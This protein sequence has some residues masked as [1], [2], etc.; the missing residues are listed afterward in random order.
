MAK[1]LEPSGYTS[2][3][4]SPSSMAGAAW[5]SDFGAAT[6]VNPARYHRAMRLF[7]SARLVARVNPLPQEAEEARDGWPPLAGFA[8]ALAIS[9]SL[10]VILIRGAMALF[11]AF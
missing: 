3:H 9:L 10:W 11:G 1:T 6:H 5:R 8:L 2:S 4:L 7:W